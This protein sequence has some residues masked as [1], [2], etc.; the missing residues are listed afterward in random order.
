LRF[1][2]KGHTLHTLDYDTNLGFHIKCMPWRAYNQSP[3]TQG[4]KK[5]APYMSKLRPRL[6]AQT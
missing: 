3:L 5:Q 6:H 1:K 4:Q 2:A